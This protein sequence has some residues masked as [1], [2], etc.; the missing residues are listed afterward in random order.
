MEEFN[1][2]LT[3]DI[4]A[5]SI[6]NNLMAAAIDTRIYHEGCQVKGLPGHTRTLPHAAGRGRHRT[7]TQEHQQPADRHNAQWAE[8]RSGCTRAST[9]SSTANF[10]LNCHHRPSG[11]R[12]ALPSAGRDEGR[13]D[14]ILASPGP[15]AVHACRTSSIDDICRQLHQ[16][17]QIAC[18][19]IR[20]R[21]L[22]AALHP[23]AAQ[24]A[25]KAWN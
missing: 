6:A 4:H 19:I 23:H 2:H 21:S 1:L 24:A 7:H 22:T 11:R 5:I 14:R 17:P 12:G 10:L 15:A 25:P 8:R 16:P 18:A 9:Q 13:L 3:G 20:R